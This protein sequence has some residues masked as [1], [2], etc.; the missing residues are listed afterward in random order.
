VAMAE[1]EPL[2]KQDLYEVLGLRKEDHPTEDQIKKAYRKLALKQHPDRAGGDEELFKKTTHAHEILSDPEKREMYDKFGEEGLNA[3]RVS[4]DEIITTAL[5]QDPAHKCTMI[6]IG[7]IV[8]GIM[9]LLPLFIF[10][11]ATDAITWS[12]FVVLIP[13]WIQLFST[14]PFLC[15][16]PCKLATMQEGATAEMWFAYCDN[17]FLTIILT[18]AA[19]FLCLRL[20]GDVNW[21]YQLIFTPIYIFEA[22]DSLTVVGQQ[23]TNVLRSLFWKAIRVVF[24]VLLG[25]HLDTGSP[26][27]AVVLIP[28]WLGA[29]VMLAALVSSYLHYKKMLRNARLKDASFDPERSRYAPFLFK[30]MALFEVC[31]VLALLLFSFHVL[32]IGHVSALAIGLPVLIGIVLAIF[33]VS[34]ALCIGGAWVM[35]PDEDDEGDVEAGKPDKEESPEGTIPL[36]GGGDAYGTFAGSGP[37]SGAGV[38]TASYDV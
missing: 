23:V 11:R 17:L 9:S 33:I 12:W 5:M 18:T 4:I 19:I 29:L 32:N 30:V 15:F 13:L 31:L 21:D 1:T 26:G 3:N 6:C 2:V 25:M 35:R 20:D 24:L 27:W 37:S 28:L 22:V 16:M 14:L 36:G 10:L 8:I 38:G 7:V 34:A